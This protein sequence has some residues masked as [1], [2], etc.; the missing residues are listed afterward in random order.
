ME[1]SV[2][3][4]FIP[5]HFVNRDEFFSNFCYAVQKAR[6]PLRKKGGKLFHPRSRHVN[7]IYFRIFLIFFDNFSR[8][9]SLN[10]SKNCNEIFNIDRG[11]EFLSRI[12]LSI[13]TSFYY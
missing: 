12:H 2:T 8:L 5:L 9:R 4:R 11:N 7:L 6:D 10:I 13:Y 1:N 3:R